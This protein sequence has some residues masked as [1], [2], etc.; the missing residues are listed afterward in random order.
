MSEG[1][2]RTTS[3]RMVLAGL[4]IGALAMAGAGSALSIEWAARMNTK[5]TASWW[6]ALYP[7]LRNGGISQWSELVGQWFYFKGGPGGF[8]A[9]QVREVKPLASKG[10]RPP[11]CT[12]HQAFAVTFQ[13][14]NLTRATPGN[15]MVEIAHERYPSLPI[16][17]GDAARIGDKSM[18]VAVFN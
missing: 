4:G 14:W 3:R 8:A 1:E 6:D 10:T 7:S 13:T 11:E 12:R 5:K 16:F 2:T 17:V 18:L 15:M 9:Y